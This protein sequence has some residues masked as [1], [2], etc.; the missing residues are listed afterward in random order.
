MS[1]SEI[2]AVES[3]LTG[4]SFLRVSRDPSNSFVY[5]KKLDIKCR[6]IWIHFTNKCTRIHFQVGDGVKGLRV[7]DH[8]LPSKAGLG[9]WRTDGHHKEAELFPIDNTLPLEASATLQAS[10]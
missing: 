7:G 1:F 8:V 6:C 5:L 10:V 3:A 4:N 2:S 9:I